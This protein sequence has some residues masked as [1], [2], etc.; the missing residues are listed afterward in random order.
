MVLKF[1]LGYEK[2]V[3]YALF[4]WLQGKKFQHLLH[5]SSFIKD[6]CPLSDLQK[7]NS[8]DSSF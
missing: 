2:I 1:K 7:Y 6:C 8:F 4:C 3:M 5:I